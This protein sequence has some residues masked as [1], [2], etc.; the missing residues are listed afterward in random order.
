MLVAKKKTTQ[1]PLSPSCGCCRVESVTTID[2]RG[3]M[4]LPKEI[5]ERAD[6]KAGD[7]LAVISLE[8]EGKSCCICLIKADEFA[9]TIRGLLG[10]ML[11]EV[12]GS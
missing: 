12:G 1:V 10:P 4:V 3:Q 2:A 8:Q 6:I 11:K 9:G 5:R 7:R